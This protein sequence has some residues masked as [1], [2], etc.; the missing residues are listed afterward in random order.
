MAEKLR[1]LLAAEPLDKRINV[2]ASFG[3]TQWQPGQ[4][5]RELV[6]CADQLLYRAKQMGR[7]RVECIALT[8]AQTQP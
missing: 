7:D 8:A 5:L 3:V 1:L 2:T 6:H 4:G